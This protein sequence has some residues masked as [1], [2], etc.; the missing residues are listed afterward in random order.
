MSEQKNSFQPR[1][2][3][4]LFESD[5]HK[6]GDHS[7][8]YCLPDQ[9]TIRSGHWTGID[10]LLELYIYVLILLCLLNAPTIHTLCDVRLLFFLFGFSLFIFSPASFFLLFSFLISFLLFSLFLSESFFLALHFFLSSCFLLSV[11]YCF[12][13]FFIISLVVFLI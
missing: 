5:L 6:K 1:S 4:V 10:R 9:R 13:F 8:Q 3:S 2:K 12:S 11:F 7:G